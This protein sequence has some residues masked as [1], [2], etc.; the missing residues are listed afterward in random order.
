MKKVSLLLLTIFTATM[1]VA[2]SDDSGGGAAAPT[3]IVPGATPTPPPSSANDG[4]ITW[5][6]EQWNNNITNATRFSELLT[7]GQAGNTTCGVDGYYPSVGFRHY[8]GNQDCEYYTQK[9]FVIFRYNPTTN[10]ARLYI[11]GL[12]ANGLA[13]G[14]SRET[15]ASNQANGFTADFGPL[16]TNGNTPDH[17]S[18]FRVYVTSPATSS[19]VINLPIEVRFGPAPV[20]DVVNTDNLLRVN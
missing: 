1:L 13:A 20:G 9:S 18:S 17:I 2:C 10:K 15:T 16:Y 14:Y 6:S 12:G 5:Q 3:P 19:S 4:F 7:F 8:F 11:Y